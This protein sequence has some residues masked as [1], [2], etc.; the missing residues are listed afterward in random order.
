MKVID[1]IVYLNNRILTKPRSKNVIACN[2]FRVCMKSPG[3]IVVTYEE[4]EI[5]LGAHVSYI[6]MSM[7]V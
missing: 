6:L 7:P 3:Y 1:S 4:N 2:Y 5:S